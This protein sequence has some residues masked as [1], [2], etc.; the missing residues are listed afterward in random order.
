MFYSKWLVS[1]LLFNKI[2]S[3][4]FFQKKRK[5]KINWGTFIFQRIWTIEYNKNNRS[6]TYYN[7][8]YGTKILIIEY[9]WWNIS[10]GIMI[11][12]NVIKVEKT[13]ARNLNICTIIDKHEKSTLSYYNRRKDNMNPMGEITTTTGTMPTIKVKAILDTSVQ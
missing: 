8:I 2:S 5:K 13:K 9:E 7:G 3:F 12:M 11:Q 1:S 6:L 10:R 4:N